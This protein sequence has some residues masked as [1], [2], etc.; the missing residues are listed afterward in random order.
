MACPPQLHA[1]F[2]WTSLLATTWCWLIYSCISWPTLCCQLHKTWI[3]AWIP[4][5]LA[6]CSHHGGDPWYTIWNMQLLQ[7]IWVWKQVFMNYWMLSLH[8]QDIDIYALELF[9]HVIEKCIYILVCVPQS[10]VLPPL[11]W[12]YI[13]L[14]IKSKMFVG[15][16]CVVRLQIL[17]FGSATSG[18]IGPPTCVFSLSM[19]PLCW[20]GFH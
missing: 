8:I 10:R 13:L 12:A 3:N 5:T 2:E 4:I 9:K 19:C 18:T 17:I 16:R 14:L 20:F 1:T 11:P 6:H 7:Q 15:F